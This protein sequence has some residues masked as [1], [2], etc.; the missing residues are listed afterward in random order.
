ME[1]HCTVVRRPLTGSDGW[2]YGD[3]AQSRFLLQ[4]HAGIGAG[5]DPTTSGGRLSLQGM[6]MCV[7]VCVS[8]SCGVSCRY[9]VYRGLISNS[10]AFKFC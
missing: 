2:E 4:L 1:E 10:A 8:A 7:C 5:D 6:C 3:E 9:H